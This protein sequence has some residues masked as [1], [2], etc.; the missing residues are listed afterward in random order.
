LTSKVIRADESWPEFLSLLDSDPDFVF[1]EFYKFASKVIKSIPPRSMRTLP[2]EDQGEVFGEIVY[3]CVKDNFRV[4]RQYSDQ[5][6]SFA[7]WLYL[8]ASNKA[9]EIARAKRNDPVVHSMNDEKRVI[10]LEETFADNS[11]DLLNQAV[12]KQVATRAFEIINKLSEK[13]RL[14]L[15]MAA[16]EFSPREVVDTLRLPQDYNKKV[17]DDLRECR[18][19]LRNRLKEEG[20]DVDTLFSG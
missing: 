5:G 19:Q 4:L 18:R 6:K 17:S 1:R 15:E 9:S 11:E 14:L 20:I 13:C 3:H 16:D 12:W 10:G 7:G 2:T 8:V